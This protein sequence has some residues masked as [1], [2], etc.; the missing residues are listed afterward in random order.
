MTYK[1][2]ST[3][4]IN[5]L[6]LPIRLNQGN[7]DVHKTSNIEPSIDKESK[8]ELSSEDTDSVTLTDNGKDQFL[9]PPSTLH[10]TS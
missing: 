5:L 6:D 4:E 9:D 10:L 2:V 3:G 7:S 1:N 8:D